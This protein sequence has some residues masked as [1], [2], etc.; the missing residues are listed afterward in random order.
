MTFKVSADPLQPAVPLQRSGN[1]P[2]STPSRGST[3]RPLL[4]DHGPRPQDDPGAVQ[5]EV[6][7][8]LKQQ[9]ERLDAAAAAETERRA[10]MPSV[11][12]QLAA[13]AARVNTLEVRDIERTVRLARLQEAVDALTPATVRRIT[14]RQPAGDAA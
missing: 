3:D 14:P 2:Y 5:R 8:R 11:S 1:Q 6:E 4:G 13:L 9:R 7:A 10:A 12:Q